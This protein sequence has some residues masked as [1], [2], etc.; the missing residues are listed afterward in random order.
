MKIALFQVYT[1]AIF[2]RDQK[3]MPKLYSSSCLSKSYISLGR[4]PRTSIVLTFHE[5]EML[6]TLLR[7][8]HS[9]I[10]RTP[11]DLLED[12]VVIDDFSNKG[13]T[14]LVIPWEIL[15]Y[16]LCRD[17]NCIVVEWESLTLAQVVVH[18]D[19]FEVVV[20]EDY[21]VNYDDIGNNGV[22]NSVSFSWS[23]AMFMSAS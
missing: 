14:K 18:E 9:V 22:Y 8:I 20:H 3:V 11:D 1:A 16:C 13:V 19:D 5:G 10:Q 7:T 15:L 21:F 12:I 6:S 23:I 4:L 2:L 17:H